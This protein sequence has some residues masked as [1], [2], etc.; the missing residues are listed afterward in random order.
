MKAVAEM[1]T[2][3]PGNKD[4]HPALRCA[5]GVFV[6]LIALTLLG[7]LDL[8]VFASF[9][10]F[11]GIYGRNEP[12]SVR[13]RSQL[14]AGGFM[15]FIILCATLIARG[16]HAWGLDATA[17]S[18]LLIVATTVVAGA[19]SVVVAAW[20]LR[21]GGSLFH[22]FAF[23]AIASI[24]TQPPLWE[25]TVV[26]VL[27]TG[28]CLLVGMSARV[29]KSHRTPWKRPPR[30]RHTPAERRAIW[31]E[32]GGYLI[33][34]GLAG[35]IA[36]LVGERLGFGHTY[37]AMVAAVVPLVGHS[38]RHRVSR[39]IQRIAGTVVGLVLLA[40]ILWLNP[41]PWAMVL[42][43]AACQFGAEMFIARQYFIAQLFVTPLA[44]IATLLAAPVDPGLLLRD[45]IIETVIGAAVGVAVVV[46]PAVWRRVR[47]RQAALIEG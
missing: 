46:A 45:R 27:T 13:F 12:H 22:I 15:L 36:T 33:A 16:E 28:F 35:T 29:V 19:C 20:R 9:G 18:W 32:G 39:G 6:P 8:A 24:P 47:V 10:A 2:M 40:G 5:V 3:G 37:W 17:Y 42:V 21:P 34:A 25:A 31:L 23:A 41:A 7:R 14:R 4:H 11:T 1:F 44:L 38:T 26:A 30:I 43:I